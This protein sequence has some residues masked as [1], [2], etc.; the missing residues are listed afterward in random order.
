MVHSLA[1][2]RGSGHKSDHVRVDIRTRRV[3]SMGAVPS[4]K[5]PIGISDLDT[6]ADTCVAGATH[7]VLERTG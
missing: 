1:P 4:D 5:R 3:N 2:V 7:K 6:H